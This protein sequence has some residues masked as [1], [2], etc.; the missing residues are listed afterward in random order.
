MSAR[1]A[2]ILAAIMTGISLPEAIATLGD[3]ARSAEPS[4]A[5]LTLGRT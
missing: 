1:G 5:D 3:R 2:A 4:P